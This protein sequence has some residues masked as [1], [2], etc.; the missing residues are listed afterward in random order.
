MKIHKMRHGI[1]AVA[2][3]LVVATAVVVTAVNLGQVDDFEDGTVMGWEEGLPSPNPPINIPD[4]GP[5]GSGDA[6]LLNESRGGAGPG[7]RMVMFNNGQWT[8]DYNALGIPLAIRAHMASSG[9]EPL[10]MRVA[11]EGATG[12]RY[13]STSGTAIPTDGM[14]YEVV[15]D[16][17]ES[18]MTLVE[19]SGTLDSVLDNVAE[20]RILSSAV[21]AWSGDSL[22][23]LLGVDNIAF[24]AVLFVDGFESGDTSAWSVTVP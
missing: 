1:R 16:L 13:A 17:S 22:A 2:A 18:A 7:S 14:W 15:F 12:A 5:L 4:G 24:D 6:Y 8:G 10:L 19:G 20:I 21:P 9:P 11:I 23:G 3:V